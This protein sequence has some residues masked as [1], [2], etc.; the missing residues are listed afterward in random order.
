MFLIL[1]NL[2]LSLALFKKSKFHVVR[3]LVC[4]P[5]MYLQ[6]CLASFSLFSSQGTEGKFLSLAVFV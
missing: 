3:K 2:L 6:A 4:L 1:C 5:Q